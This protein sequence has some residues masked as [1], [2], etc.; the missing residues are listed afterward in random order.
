MH[1]GHTGKN[2]SNSNDLMC[3]SGHGSVAEIRLCTE[4][5]SCLSR[6]GLNVERGRTLH[7]M[8]DNAADGTTV[9]I[10]N[11]LQRKAGAQPVLIQKRLFLPLVATLAVLAPLSANAGIGYDR[12]DFL[13]SS[14]IPLNEFDAIV[15]FTITAPGSIT[16]P[17]ELTDFTMPTLPS[18]ALSEL[19]QPSVETPLHRLFCVEYARA[20]SGLTVF[21]DAKFWWSRARNLYA[22]VTMPVENAVIVFSGSKRLKKGHVAVVTNI[23]STREIRVDQANWENHGEIDHATPVLDVSAKNDW[24]KVRVWDMRSNGFGAHVYAISGFIANELMKRASND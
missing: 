17:I 18:A 9:S 3:L 4:R 1:N 13:A 8:S 20:R 10:G 7:R 19:P 5:I 15:P 14:A 16:K 23:V 11:Y 2:T 12:P 21:G 22:R 24:S 6:S